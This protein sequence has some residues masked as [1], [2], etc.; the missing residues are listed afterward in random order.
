MPKDEVIDQ[1]ID[2]TNHEID[3]YYENSEEQFSEFVEKTYQR[4]QE[5]YNSQDTSL[6]NRIKKDVDFLLWNNM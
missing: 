1:I 2:N 4:F 5:L 3:N 6:W